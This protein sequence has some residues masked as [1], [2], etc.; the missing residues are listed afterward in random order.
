MLIE[1][2]RP[3]ETVFAHD[4]ANTVGASEIGACARQTWFKKNGVAGGEAAD[5][6]GFR[7]RGKHVEA[8]VYA[9][10]RAA[11]VRLQHKQRTLTSGYLSATLDGFWRGL[12]VD[13]KSVDPRKREIVEPKHV[14]QVKVQIGLWN[15]TRRTKAKGGLLLYVDASDYANL[16]EFPVEPDPDAYAAAHER[17]RRIMGEHDPMALPA[18]GRIAGGR[19]CER[20]PFQ[21]ACLGAP[22]EDKGRLTSEERERLEVLRS[23]VSIEEKQIAAAEAGIARLR[24]TARE[25]LRGADVRRVPGVCSVKRSSRTSLDTEALTR[26]GIDLDKYRKPGK[27]TETVSWS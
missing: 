22:I 11:G 26:D 2:L 6:W 9:R 23:C 16:R 20:C 10:L 18:E 27:V 17:A 1:H 19:E 13:V 15:E 4:R 12:C 7:E 21:V 25:I 14:L 8:W 3:T 5:G 24:E